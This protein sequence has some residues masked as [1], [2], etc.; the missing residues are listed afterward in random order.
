MKARSVR[1]EIPAASV[2]SVSATQAEVAEQIMI[3]LIRIMDAAYEILEHPY[4]FSLV[5][6]G[7]L[8]RNPQEEN[9]NFVLS[10]LW[11]HLTEAPRR[12]EKNKKKHR[13]FFFI[14]RNERGSRFLQWQRE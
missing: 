8:W 11:V 5:C 6:S 12:T 4:V 2:F 13:C 1:G 9:F 7:I 14:K 10:T 3:L